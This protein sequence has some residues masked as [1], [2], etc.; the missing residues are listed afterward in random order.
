MLIEDLSDNICTQL[1]ILAPQIEAP[2]LLVNECLLDARKHLRDEFIT[3]L[4]PYAWAKITLIYHKHFLDSG[5]DI[6]VAEIVIAV[7]RDSLT[8]N[9]MDMVTLAL[10]Q[11]KKE[12]I[13][14]SYSVPS[15]KIVKE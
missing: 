9:R 11:Q 15:L 14:E 10:S 12:P 13:Q 8:T 4:S 1:H 5:I 7:I 2:A 6:S 3:M